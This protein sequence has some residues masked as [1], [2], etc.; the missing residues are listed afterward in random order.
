VSVETGI[1]PDVLADLD[2]FWLDALTEVLSAKAKAASGEPDE[3]SLDWDAMHP[4]DTD[5]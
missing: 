4:D 2:G 5:D 3:D 1:P